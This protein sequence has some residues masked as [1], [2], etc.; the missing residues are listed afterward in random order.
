[1]T[2]LFPPALYESSRQKATAHTAR[3]ARFPSL[4]HHRPALPII[5]RLKMV[6]SYVLSSLLIVENEMA[7]PVP[8]TL[9][10]PEAKSTWEAS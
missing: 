2:V 3:L 1:M 5:Q 8:G 10:S 4:G 6:A 7:S 9:S